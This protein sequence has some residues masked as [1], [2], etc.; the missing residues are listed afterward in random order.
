MRG[1]I[2]SPMPGI[3]YLGELTILEDKLEINFICWILKHTTG[4]LG[5]WRCCGLIK[6]SSF[7]LRLRASLVRRSL[8]QARYCLSCGL[9]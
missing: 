9:F 3:R 5:A 2:V 4:S 6:L 8:P 7:C 1:F